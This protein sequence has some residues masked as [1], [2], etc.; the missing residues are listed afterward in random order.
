VPEGL[1]A[2]EAGKELR[3]HA[4]RDEEDREKRLNRTVS[5][6]E[7]TLLAVVAVLAAWSGYAAAKWSTESSL[8]LSRA[9]AARAEANAANLAALNA[10]NFDV[11]AFNAWFT[12]YVAGN[13]SAMSIAQKRFTPNFQR[14]FVAWLA[15][16]PAT[17][18]NAPP[19]PTYMP[20]YKQPQVTRAD[21][22][23]ALATKEY[24]AGAKA[25]SNSDNYV[26]TTVYLATVLFLAGIG[27]HFSYRGIR[28][29][30]ATVSLGI[31][32]VAVILL[33]AAPKPP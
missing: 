20:Q 28:Y 27:S 11:T 24:A 30:L 4:E 9:S 7:A 33:A 31:L 18:P 23:N 29:G 3:E 8:S 21:Q 2:T 6:V 15:T 14:A 32:T 17:N 25:G 1:S 16:K 13:Q 12:A 19:G 5:I 22:L 26:L 10:V